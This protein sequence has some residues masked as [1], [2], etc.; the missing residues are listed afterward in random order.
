MIPFSLSK[1]CCGEIVGFFLFFIRLKGW[2]SH[3]LVLDKIVTIILVYGCTSNMISNL[4]L[5]IVAEKRK[6]VNSVGITPLPS[7]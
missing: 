5:R 6:K 7:N 3:Y 1:S 4:F 2:A